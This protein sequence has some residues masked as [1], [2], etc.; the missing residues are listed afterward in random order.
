MLKVV[1]LRYGTMFKKAF[2][3]REVFS[4]FTS[5]VLGLPIHVETVHQEYR[6][7]EPVGRVN[8]TYDLF[9]EDVAH[10]LI[11]EVQHIREPDF[12]DRFLHY[13]AVSIVEQATSP[14]NYRAGRT[15]YTVVVLTTPP[16]S[17]RLRFSMAVSDLDPVNEHG[18]RLGVYR[19]R[20]IFLSP[21]YINEQT[22]PAVRAWLELIADSLDGEVD[23]ARFGDPLMQ[24]V[25][26]K[27]RDSAI[28]PEELSRVKDEA[29]WEE[30]LREGTLEG[31][32]KGMLQGKREAL[33]LVAR[34]VGLSLDEEA[35]AAVEACEDVA[36][37]D[38]WIARVPRA[39]NVVEVLRA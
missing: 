32:Q 18:A 10:R 37:L 22:P 12:F 17:E 8:V 4:R 34:A 35:R 28:S 20:L 26:D 36:T 2:S 33:L 29:G 14:G 24:R 21:K 16:R 9:A 1:P 38:R 27:I 19:H 30:A 15:V 6:Y 13:H 23:E 7:P 39:K 31:E 5:D 11:V 25:L 3:D